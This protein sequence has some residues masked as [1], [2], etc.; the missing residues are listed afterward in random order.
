M[1]IDKNLELATAAALTVTAI[2]TDV[3]D[4]GVTPVLKNI[5][6]G[7][8]LYAVFMV[9]TAMLAAGAATLEL[10]V[11]T[12]SVVGLGTSPTVHARTTPIPKAL[13]IAGY[14]RVLALPPEFLYE[15]YLGLRLTVATGPFTAGAYSCIITPNLQ[16]WAALADRL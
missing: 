8:P 3:I 6:G 11:E 5:S 13:L 9:T 15:R 7:R 14:S 4:L 2:S 12:D 16:T 10:S 1:I